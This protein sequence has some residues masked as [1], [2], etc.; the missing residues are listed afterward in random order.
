MENFPLSEREIEKIA[1][2][3]CKMQMQV[4]VSTVYDKILHYNIA[5]T[6]EQVKRFA[7]QH[8][9]EIKLFEVWN[10]G[11]LQFY[12]FEKGIFEF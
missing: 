9:L 12:N 1:F 7:I 4:E 11:R 5:L 6:F 10:N 3:I 8:K 2:Y